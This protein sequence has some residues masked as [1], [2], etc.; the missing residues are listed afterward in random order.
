MYAWMKL[1]ISICV[2]QNNIELNARISLLW[3]CHSTTTTN[4][5][6]NVVF[7]LNADA[8]PP[9]TFH[10]VSHFTSVNHT[11]TYAHPVAVLHFRSQYFFFLCSLAFVISMSVHFLLHLFY[12]KFQCVCAYV[13]SMHSKYSTACVLDKQKNTHRW[14]TRWVH[15]M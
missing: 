8:I 11:L 14:N 7:L 6:K 3:Q 15:S 1:H 5:K 13:W 9:Q 4:W 2:Y 12:T 10:F